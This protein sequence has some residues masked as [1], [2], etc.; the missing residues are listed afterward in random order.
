MQVNPAHP[1]HI[2]TKEGQTG[3]E[4]K[5]QQESAVRLALALCRQFLV[6]GEMLERV[7]VFKYLSCLLTQDDN[8]AQHIDNNCKKHG[9]YG[10][11][12]G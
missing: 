4:Q 11:V 9:E 5:S 8:N 2:W 1:Q 6:H 12:W 7:E 10:P 3:V